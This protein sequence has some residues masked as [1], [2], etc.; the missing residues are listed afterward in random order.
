MK[1]R[2]AILLVLTLGAVL[3]PASAQANWFRFGFG[4]DGHHRAH[5]RFGLGV[6]VPIYPYAV[7]PDYYYYGEPYV[8]Y[9]P[10]PVQA[11]Y[12][13]LQIQVEPAEVEIWVD[14]RLVGRALDFRGPT[15]VS[16][17]AGSHMVEFR[18][19]GQTT[20]T[21]IYVGPGSTSVISRNLTAR[22]YPPPGRPASGY[23]RLDVTPADAVVYLDGRFSSVAGES[24][25]I[26]LPP[27]RHQVEVVMPGYTSYSTEVVIHPGKES[28]LKITLGNLLSKR[29]R[30]SS[31]GKTP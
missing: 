21:Q 28:S 19:A 30:G 24:E 9:K 10:R 27:G 5:T 11:G 16:V 20:T 29:G 13:T 4:W 22:P 17:P 26:T 15:L 1:T 6:T 8:A 12:G 3:L 18:L 23:L 2:L 7:Y 25:V 31:L 14:G